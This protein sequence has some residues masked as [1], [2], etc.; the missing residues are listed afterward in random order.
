MTD[1]ALTPEWAAW[2]DMAGN[3]VVRYMLGGAMMP[4]SYQMA[5]A[6]V[7]REQ[8][9]RRRHRSTEF[10]VTTPRRVGTSETKRARLTHVERQVLA[11]IE[12]EV[13][14]RLWLATLA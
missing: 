5:V 14:T 7:E 10:N 3:Q 9:P 13:P 8:D 12:L 4:V 6:K 1:G 11:G 2:A